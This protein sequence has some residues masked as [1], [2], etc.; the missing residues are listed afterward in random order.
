MNKRTALQS[1]SVLTLTAIVPSA[2]AVNAGEKHEPP[3]PI[4]VTD[5]GISKVKAGTA[6]VRAALPKASTD[7]QSLRLSLDG[8]RVEGDPRLSPEALDGILAPWKGKEL[9]FSEYEAAIHAVA[10]YLREHGHPGAQVK[11]SRAI[12]GQGKVM[13]AIEGL[14]PTTAAVAEA[15]VTPRVDVKGFKVTGSSLL[16]EADLQALLAGFAGKPLTAAEM[17]QAA[18]AVADR[19]RAMGYPLVQAYLPRQRVDGGI[20]EIAVLEGRLDPASGRNGLLVE[21]GGVRIKPSVMEEFIAR[22][23]KPGQPLRVADLERAVLLSGDLPG[24][25]SVSTVI[26]PGTETGSTRVRA[27]VEEG[28]LFSAS[29]WADN[30][31]NRYTGDGRATGQFLLNSPTGNGEQYGLNLVASSDSTSARLSVTAPA[32]RDGLRLG[33]AYAWTTA[34]FGDDMRTID[35]SSDSHDFT[36]NASY[37]IIRSAQKNLGFSAAYDRKRYI[38]DLS[39]GR[40][41]DRV[42]DT[43]TLGLSGDFLDGWGGQTRWSAALAGG[44]LDLSRHAEYQDAD[45]KTAQTA[46]GYGKLNWQVSRVAPLAGSDRWSWMLATSGQVA[47]KN[48]DSAEKFQLGG[49]QG[50]RAYPVSEGVGDHGWLLNAEL[51]YRLPEAYLKDAHLFG[52]ADAGGVTQYADP[53]NDPITGLPS[54]GSRPNTYTL[55]G[56]GLGANVGFGEQGSLKLMWAKKLGDNPNADPASNNDSDGQNKSSRV[57][58]LGNIVF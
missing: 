58:I 49:P 15:E 52:F 34:S 38:T 3:R 11:M 20:V 44:D 28:R 10:Q 8:F 4:E 55:K 53:Y 33:A 14:T 51:R 50:V 9:S 42:M 31:G 54:L 36:L 12:I 24:V 22:G 19:L 29:L 30:F 41:N 26:E 18:Q 56:V 7:R 35:L 32:G 47:S 21:G 17:E 27:K 13:I 37:P 46:G 57:W 16:A 43:L 2:L 40:E 1:V 5:T 6:T 23:A 39:W 25:K 45:A 48:L